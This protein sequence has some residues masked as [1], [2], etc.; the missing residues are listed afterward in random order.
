V[1][2]LDRFMHTFLCCHCRRK[3]ERVTDFLWK[4]RRPHFTGREYSV[5]VGPGDTLGDL[6][7]IG[8]HPLLENIFHAQVYASFG[9]C[10]VRED[11]EFFLNDR[12]EDHLRYLVSFR[13]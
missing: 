6:I 3:R 5:I 4:R 9:R 8:R 11:I 13:A 2:P 12:L 10:W 7:G 1:N